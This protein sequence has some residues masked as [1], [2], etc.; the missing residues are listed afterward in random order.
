MSEPTQPPKPISP[1]RIFY[2]VEV[3]HG[4][5]EELNNQACDIVRLGVESAIAVARMQL[6]NRKHAPKIFLRYEGTVQA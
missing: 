4:A 3:I 1:V 2:T 5:S 6:L